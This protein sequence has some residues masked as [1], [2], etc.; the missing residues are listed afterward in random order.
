MERGCTHVNHL[1]IIA[2]SDLQA[3]RIACYKQK[4]SFNITLNNQRV[5]GCLSPVHLPEPLLALS[6]HFSEQGK[7]SNTVL[8][9]NLKI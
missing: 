4:S 7:N 2:S 8:F 6:L 3:F 9:P 1:I 5:V